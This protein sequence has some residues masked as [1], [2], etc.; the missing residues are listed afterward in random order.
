MQ[1]PTANVLAVSFVIQLYISACTV[2]VHHY[3]YSQLLLI[4]YHKIFIKYQ[5]FQ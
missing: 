2:H 5:V 3:N 1:S 4:E